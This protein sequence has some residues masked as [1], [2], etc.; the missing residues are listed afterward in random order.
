M[1]EGDVYILTSIAVSSNLIF[2]PSRPDSCPCDRAVHQT[3][4]MRKKGMGARP[5]QSSRRR[6]GRQRYGWR[7]P[8][9]SGRTGASTQGAV[10]MDAAT[11]TTAVGSCREHVPQQSIVPVSIG[12]VH[13]N[14][15]LEIVRARVFV[16]LVQ[17]EGANVARRG[18]NETVSDAWY[19]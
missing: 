8:G 2:V 18:V 12:V 1:R 5:S 13:A 9:G 6:G 4:A 7:G 17:T 15:P 11:C 3:S 19:K 14:M 10:T 16:L